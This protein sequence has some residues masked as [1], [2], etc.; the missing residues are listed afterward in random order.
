M[1]KDVDLKA[2]GPLSLCQWSTEGEDV[3]TVNFELSYL[4]LYFMIVSL[5]C[6]SFSLCNRLISGHMTRHVVSSFNE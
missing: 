2:N 6:H 5:L 1:C 3:E 4:L